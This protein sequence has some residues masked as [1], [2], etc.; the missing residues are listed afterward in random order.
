MDAEER[1]SPEE[2]AE[3]T[4]LSAHHLHRYRLAAR[5]CGGKRVVDLGCGTGYGADLLARGGA[6]EVLGVDIDPPTVAGATRRYGRDGLRFAAGDAVE[7]LG[8]L[9]AEDVDVVVA[10]ESLEHLTDLD[11]AL[12][13]LERLAG[14]GVRLVLSVPNSAMWE[15]D[16]AFHVTDF[17]ARSARAAFGRF[18]DVVVLHQHLAEGSVLLGDG[19]D[20]EGRPFSGELREVA[21]GEPE[22]A[23]SFVALVGFGGGVVDGA[24]AHL[25]VVVTPHQNRFMLGLERAN[26]QL[27]QANSALATG[28]LGNGD[29]GAA[30]VLAKY[31]SAQ[32]EL[33]RL[34]AELAAKD[35]RIAEIVEIAQ[36]NDDLF[37]LE[38]RHHDARR[39]RIA[40]RVAG[41]LSKARLP[42]RG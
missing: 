32:P 15:E 1:L 9:G 31:A 7:V 3:P 34:R 39:Y 30:T 11:G 25:N 14:H 8:G 2:V 19:E 27:R 37:Q 23:Q 18:D 16:N 33:E 6:E 10:F 4:I 12:A 42:G 38:R 28:Y 22:Y 20:R 24:L 5:L 26:R 21:N 40:D 36:R 35:A 29:A 41:A 13:Q 17:D